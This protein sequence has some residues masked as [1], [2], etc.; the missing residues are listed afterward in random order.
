MHV[1][2]EAE[3][4]RSSYSG[5]GGNNCVEVAVI[6]HGIAI[7]DSKRPSPILTFNPKAFTALVRSVA[8]GPLG[9]PTE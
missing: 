4:R 7:R 2:S 1:L 8:A 6:P 5:D 3:W 9:P